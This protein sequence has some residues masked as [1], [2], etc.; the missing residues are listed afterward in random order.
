[1][2]N[3][4]I[5]SGI[6]FLSDAIDHAF[7][8]HCLGSHVG[9]YALNTLE[10]ENWTTELLSFFRVTGCQSKRPARD[11]D[12][13]GVDCGSGLDEPILSQLEPLS[14]FPKHT[15]SGNPHV[16]IPD[17]RMPPSSTGHEPP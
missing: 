9:E 4:S 8:S 16:C 5:N 10:V 14:D 12:T 7:P 11:P 13:T 15:I 1:M 2:S 3:L 17:V 6:D